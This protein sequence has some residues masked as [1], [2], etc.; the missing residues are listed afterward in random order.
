MDLHGLVDSGKFRQDLFFRLGEFTIQVPPL[1][2][3]RDEIPELALKIVEEAARLFCKPKWGVARSAEA[4]LQSHSWPGNVRELKNVMRKATLVSTDGI[5][6]DRDLDISGRVQTGD[7]SSNPGLP[8]DLI[9]PQTHDGRSL[10]EIITSMIRDIETRVITEALTRAGG[11]KSKAA[12]ALQLD[13]TTLHR[14]I[15]DYG[16]RY[17]L[18]AES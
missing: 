6:R 1:R 3:R 16:I 7:L 13:Y 18:Q 14:K 12:I 5:V 17:H 11:N 9:Q 4:L 2:E 15:K 10:R 8:K